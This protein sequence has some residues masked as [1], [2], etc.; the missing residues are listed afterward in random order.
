[1]ERKVDKIKRLERELWRYRKKVGDDG[2]ELERLRKALDQANKGIRETQILVDAVLTAVALEYGEDARD[3]DGGEKILGKRL[4]LPEIRV[5]E[6]REKYEIH[7]GKDA[8]T[9]GF[10]VGV[11]ERAEMTV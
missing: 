3:P 5:T 2:K 4:L 10:S 7:A 9:G 8:E 1:M 6:L 11:V